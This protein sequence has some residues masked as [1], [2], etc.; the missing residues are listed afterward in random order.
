MATEP[1]TVPS[2]RKVPESLRGKESERGLVQPPHAHPAPAYL[3][4]RQEI[5]SVPQGRVSSG[6]KLFPSHLVR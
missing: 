1:V 4:E 5:T 2:P 3:M 6:R